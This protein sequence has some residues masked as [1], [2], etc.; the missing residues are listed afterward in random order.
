MRCPKSP[1]RAGPACAFR[2]L[3]RAP[4]AAS[5]PGGARGARPALSECLGFT[6][7][8]STKAKRRPNGRHFALAGAEGLEPSALGFGV[9]EREISSPIRSPVFQG[10]RRFCPL[11]GFGF[12][13][14]LMLCD[15]R[16]SVFGNPPKTD[17]GDTGAPSAGKWVTIVTE[18]KSPDAVIS[19]SNALTFRPNRISIGRKK[20]LLDERSFPCESLIIASWRTAHGPLTF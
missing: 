19:S 9:A 7:F 15:S 10:L 12:D 3:R 11:P 4:L 16:T 17:A 13:A 6:R 14:L 8:Y 5:A 20:Y 18:L 1:A 2:P